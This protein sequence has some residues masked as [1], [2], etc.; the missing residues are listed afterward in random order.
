MIMFEHVS[1]GTTKNSAIYA[2]RGQSNG[3][4]SHKSRLANAVAFLSSSEEG[5]G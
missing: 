3:K 2:K 5:Q 1:E 4:Q